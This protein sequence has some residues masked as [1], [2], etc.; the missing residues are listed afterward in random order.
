MKRRSLTLVICLLA[1]LSLASVGFASWV[2]SAGDTENVTGNV[3]VESVIDRRLSISS[4]VFDKDAED[5]DIK[6]VKFGIPESYAADAENWLKPDNDQDFPRDQLEIH[7]T[8]SV[9]FKDHTTVVSDGSDKN[10][11]IE[12]ELDDDTKAWLKEAVELGYIKSADVLTAVVSGGSIDCTLTF[13]W[14]ALFGYNNPWTYYNGLSVFGA[15]NGLDENNG[16]AFVAP[17]NGEHSETPVDGG[18]PHKN[19]VFDENGK[20]TGTYTITGDNPDTVEVE[21]EYTIDCD[22]YNTTYGD[23]AATF[24]QEMYDYLNTK[25]YGVTITAN[26]HTHVYDQDG[27][28]CECGAQEPTGE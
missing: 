3:Q 2:I 6:D 5:N 25:T 26:E 18:E 19:H 28:K 4:I 7:F 12:V 15:L 22:C 24:L 21:P 13:E 17:E 9:S 10:V 16:L 14:G 1:T 23:H 27:N 8:T 11:N 20:C